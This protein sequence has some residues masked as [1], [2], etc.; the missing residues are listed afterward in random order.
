M[1]ISLVLG[2]GVT[3]VVVVVQ[4]LSVSTQAVSS[5]SGA[6]GVSFDLIHRHSPLSPYSKS[7]SQQQLQN[8]AFRSPF[9]TDVIP[10]N[11]PDN[12]YIMRIYVGI[13][14]IETWAVADSGSDL[15]WLQCLPCINC[16]PQYP[17]IFD[18]LQSIS[19]T[20]LTCD[21]PYCIIDP[22]TTSCGI[23]GLCVYQYGYLDESTTMGD[24]GMDFINFGTFIH[25]KTVLG[26]GRNQ[27]GEAFAPT[28]AGVVGLGN[29][30]LSLVSQL[31]PIIGYKFSYCLVPY[32]SNSTGNLKLGEIAAISQPLH[33]LASTPYTTIPG[34]P[35]YL[36]TIEGILIYM[37]FVFIHS[38]RFYIFNRDVK[39]LGWVSFRLGYK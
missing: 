3:I 15:V 19:Y 31:G 20:T 27:T 6:R 8:A 11:D 12:D 33:Q 28:E 13:P 25:H 37:F 7:K 38:R 23:S 9:E 22:N 16:Y 39:S 34:Q 4:V 32:S 36:L 17:P 30:P 14:P 29:G 18:P 10:A 1:H 21:S 35:F 2:V 5:V 26:C 24:L